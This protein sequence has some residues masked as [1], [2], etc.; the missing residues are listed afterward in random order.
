MESTSNASGQ[1]L[2]RRDV[3]R[4]A[5]CGAVA[6][7]VS[8]W[9]S[10]A[11][12][13]L[14]A[15]EPAS[16][17]R[18]RET[19]DF[20][21]RFTK[22]DTSG[23]EL[24]SFADA[25][26]ADVDLPHDWSIEGPYSETEPASGPG[27]YLP[28]GIGWYRKRFTIPASDHGR[29]VTLEFDGVYQNSEV[30]IN[31]HSLGVR[32]YGFIPFAYEITPCLRFGAENVVAVR[33]D[34]SRQTSCRWYSGSGIYRHAWLL[35]TAPLRIAYWGTFVSSPQVGADRATVRVETT[36][37]NGLD[38]P[39]SC[40]LATALLDADRN[41]VASQETPHTIAAG[42]SF[43]FTQELTVANPKL[44]SV[45]Q[46]Y[47]YTVRCKLREGSRIV[48][49]CDTPAGIRSAVFDVDRGFLLNSEHVK[50]RGVCVHPE[51]GCVGAAVPERVWERRLAELRAMGCNAIR[52]SHNPFAAEFLDLCD[53]MGFLVMNEAFDE[54]RVPKG[55]IKDGYH[56]Y[57]DEWHERDLKNFVHRDRNH[58]S[59]VLW[60]A[61][62]EVPDQSAPDGVEALRGLLAIFHAE[63]PTR[64]VTVACDQIA[65]EPLAN[66]VRPEFLAELDIVGYNYVDRW[67]ERADL[68]YSIDRAAFPTR[69]FIGTESVAI[70]GIRGEYRDL[71]AQKGDGAVPWFFHPSNLRIDAEQLWQFVDLHDYVAGDFLWTGIDYLGE[72]RWPMKSAPS[73]AL[74]TCCFRKDS[75][76]FY[77]SQWTAQPMV[78]LFPH[79][80]WKGSEGAIIPVVCYTNCDTVELFLNGKSLGVKGYEFPRL[81]ME[82]RYGNYPPRARVLRTTADLH[83]SWDVPWE[84]GT[85]RAIGTKDGKTAVVEEIFTTGDPAVLL[86]TA[87]RT[88]LAAVCHDIARRD[89]A[90]LTVDVQDA[91][92]RTVPTADNDVTFAIEGPGRLIGV[93]NGDPFSH[94]SYKASSRRAFNGLCLAIV[95]STAKA[96]QI[97][98]TASSPGLQSASVVLTTG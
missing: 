49:V 60:S 51:G 31:G 13:M 29:V 54:W 28:T 92:G 12:F 90:H 4:Q 75:F 9:L 84:A 33:V 2:T 16:S 7:S 61:G 42:A 20:D 58:P 71:V 38:H 23:A 66:R 83:L 68:Y 62:N 65:S 96:G 85:L 64:P 39:A 15:E 77:Q 48:D 37:T 91:Q 97:N 10:R 56:L 53:R 69:R 57:F 45:D 52:T 93:D 27:G 98:V 26:W 43:R 19:F 6:C 3:L 55:Q 8:P 72:S 63:D 73:G 40:A 14:A 59:V 88:R 89:V 46:P 50:L 32:P 17:A 87:D 80:N 74:D 35:T 94:T 76:Y 78:H 11:E 34:N 70:G 95:E 22:G 21:W 24:P 18:I 30:W 25:S 81:G 1:L 82:G 86:V 79:W 36:V 44:W 5:G 67:R 41:I 47:L